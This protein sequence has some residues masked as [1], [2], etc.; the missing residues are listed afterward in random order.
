MLIKHSWPYRQQRGLQIYSFS[1]P[2]LARF[3]WSPT[4]ARRKK[5]ASG[6]SLASRVVASIVLAIAIGGSA[7]W[8]WKLF[9]EERP[10]QSPAIAPASGVASSPPPSVPAASLSEP[11]TESAISGNTLKQFNVKT[12][13]VRLG[14]GA[15][16]NYC[17]IHSGEPPP[18]ALM[19]PPEQIACS[20][21]TIDTKVPICLCP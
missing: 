3:F 5:P 14:V 2:S 7:P 6:D 13:D 1:Q 17:A 4:M 20:N 21:G 16:R 19:N 8:W 9:Q 10:P 12:L 18:R 15:L 11:M